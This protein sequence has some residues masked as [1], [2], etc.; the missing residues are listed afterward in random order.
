MLVNQNLNL[1]T[2]FLQKT[3]KKRAGFL[4]KKR[5]SFISGIIIHKSDK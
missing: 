3:L 1:Y 2:I 5:E 4:K